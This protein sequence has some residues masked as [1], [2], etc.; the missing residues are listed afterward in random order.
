[1]IIIAL[2]YTADLALPWL[3]A[4][5]LVLAGMTAM[6]RLRI[7]ALWPYLL[8][9]VILW[10]C[11]LQSG[12]HATLAGVAAAFTVPLVPSRAR[13]DD[14]RS[15]L[16]RLEHALHPWVA[17]A[18]VPIFGFANAGVSFAGTSLASLMQ[19]VAAGVALGLFL[20]KQI[21]VFGSTWLAVRLGW[22]DCPEDASW[23]QVYGARILCGIGFTVSL[24]IGLLAFPGDAALQ[25]DVKLGVLAGSLVS[26]LVGAAVLARAPRDIA[27]GRKA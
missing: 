15:P 23:A 3:A 17:F 27:R 2:F 24:F 21:G 6:N 5:A 18:V 10:A 22:A 20:G 9:A 12:V 26:A 25:N 19:P 16:H 13:P 8:G 1:V 7:R 14:V 11:T 4:A